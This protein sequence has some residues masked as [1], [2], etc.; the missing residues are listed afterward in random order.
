MDQLISV[1]APLI[2]AY[3]GE[4]GVAIQIVSVIGTLRV[5]FK[6]I[7][8]GIEKAIGDSE[9][10]KDD[11]ILGEVKQNAIFKAFIFIIDLVGSIKIK[12]K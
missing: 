6:P 12:S 10:K 11:I 1:L 3:A 5:F 7:F 4:F 9:S 2:S 8:A